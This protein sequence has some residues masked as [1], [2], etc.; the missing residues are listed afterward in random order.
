MNKPFRVFAALVAA[1]VLVLALGGTSL[2]ATGDPVLLNE[3]LAS[4]TGT[5]NTEYIELYGVPGTSLEGLSVIVVESD[6]FSPGTIDR[7]FD[8]KP[9]H[10]LGANGFFLIG[11]CAGVVDNYGVTP[12]ASLFSD[13]LENSSLTVALVETDSLAGG[14]GDTVSGSEVVLDTVALNDGDAGDTFFFDAPVIGPDGPFFPAGARRL[15]DGEDTDTAADWAISD[16]FLGPDNTPVSG[17]MDG[18]AP[19][20]LTIPEIQG[21]GERSIYEGEVVTT[22]GVVTLYSGNGR[23]FWMQDPDGDG[24]PATSDGLLV[25]DGGFLPGP[26]QV[27]DLITITAVIDEQQFGNALPLTRLD[28]PSAAGVLSSGNPLPAAVVLRDLPNEDITDGIDF[29]EPLEGMRVA[30]HSVFVNAATNGFGEFGFLTRADARKGSGFFPQN[31][32]LL[33]TFDPATGE[34]DYNPER[35][36]VDDNALPPPAV[37]P[38]DRIHRVVGVVD[39]TFSNYKLQLEEIAGLTSH[40]IPDAPVSERSGHRGNVRVTSFNVENLFDLIDNPDK[41]D[42]G[43]TPSPEELEIKLT[44]LALAVEMELELPEI[45]VVQE[46]ENTEILQE[47]GDRVNASAGTNYVATSFETS[48]VRGI[49]VGFLWDDDRVDLLQAFQ[50]S[51]QDVEDAFGPGSASPG[52]EPLVGVFEIGGG[53]QNPLTIVGNHFKSKGGD[54][55]L[56]GVVQPPVRITEVQR[57]MQ[58][59]V[60]R[61]FVNAILDADPDAWVMVAGDLNDFQFPEPNE[62]PDHPLGILAGGAGEV[63]L[64]NLIEREAEHERYTFVFDG[65][66]QVLDHILVSPALLDDVSGQDILHFNT[67]FPAIL[68]MDATTP[69]AASDHDAV[70]ARL[71]VRRPA[72]AFGL[73]LLHNNDGESQLINAG[74]GLEDF[75][76]VAR[77]AT[78]VDDLRAQSPT[79]LSVL[80]SGSVLLSSGD[81]FL[82]GPEFNASL[83]KGVPFYD[84]IAIDLIGYDAMALGNHEFDFGPDVLADFITG[85]QGSLPFVS[86]NL[87]FTAE[88]NLQAL[89]DQ[90][91]IVKRTVIHEAG[92][93]IGVVGATTPDLPFISSPRD[94]VVD[95]AVAAAIQAEID[96]LQSAGVNKIVVISHLQGVDEDLALAGEISG[97]DV[98]I[99]GGGDEVLANPDDLLVPGDVPFGPYPLYAF[100]ADGATIPVVTTAGDYKYVGR[101]VVGFNDAGEVMAVDGVSGPVR[102]AGGAN[103]DAVAPDPEIQAQVV[104]PVAD[105]LEDLANN[106]IGVSEVDLDGRRNPGVRTMETNEGNLVADSLFWQATELASSFGVQ[107]PD[108]ALQNGGGIRNNNVIPA[109]PISELT[110]FDI[111]PFSNFVTIVEDI[112]R[113]QF[114][115]IMENAVS[116]VEFASGRFAQISGFTMVYDP[117]GTPQELDEDGNV[118]TPGSRVLEITLDDG[119]PIVSGGGVVAGDPLT[120]A[121]ID[122]LARGGDQYPYR[123]APFTSLGVTYQ[124]ALRDYIIEPLGGLISAADY[125]EGGEGRITT[126]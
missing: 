45:V 46:V 54:D 103:P 62:G 125:P 115:E 105:Y 52:R 31:Q 117:T 116:Q 58:A 101:L 4:H 75:G 33:L 63:P 2:A 36:M 61:D 110:T 122:F 9:F 113:D 13:Y 85:F 120:I 104:E 118:I 7:R 39:Y 83:E 65:N 64:H 8:F 42:E 34:V 123:G 26:P 14:E 89:V 43:S 57:K 15:V 88:P 114:K 49:E 126:P 50:M 106:V 59:Q 69:L 70:E 40:P 17:G 38:G 10:A 66:S 93:R 102:V 95:P 97:V 44:K 6:S 84:T 20:E 90:G 100:G 111:A 99:A 107:A 77:F 72:S 27:G 80:R 47:V 74:A 112:P 35:I 124:Q 51:G 41:E 73:T 92:E 81:N 24:N 3:V 71:F 16:F 91:V 98:M 96:A 79:E 86:A 67:D 68:E 78:L 22:S 11:N 12:D 87:D 109:G 76:G 1:L 29:W 108:V 18:C 30:A 32:K 5:D 55:P 82:A 19:L 121:T 94:V 48:D 53:L 119:T 21:D 56:Y 37:R 60:V 25:D 23:D 28:S